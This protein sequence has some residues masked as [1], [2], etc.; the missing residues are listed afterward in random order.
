M[1]KMRKEEIPNTWMGL[2]YK[3]IFY[4]TKE[5]FLFLIILL[6]AWVITLI[7]NPEIAM[8]IK[9]WIMGKIK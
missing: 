1:S 7:I 3:I 8:S 4:K 6:I 9:A 2:I 5:F